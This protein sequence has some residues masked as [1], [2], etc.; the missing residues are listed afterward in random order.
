MAL[1]S[2]E[3]GFGLPVIEAMSAGCP[4]VCSDIDI[5]REVGG[6]AGLYFDPNSSDEI[7]DIIR[8]LENAKYR[9]EIVAKGLLNAKRF[10]WT[11]S[12]IELKL[13]LDEI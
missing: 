4:V 1:P 7:V 9:K 3:E 12:A 8:Q 11:K 2:R 6:E 13:F 10:S 5:F